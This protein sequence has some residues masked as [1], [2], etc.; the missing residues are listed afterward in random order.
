MS[1]EKWVISGFTGEHDEA[2][3]CIRDEQGKILATTS[4]VEKYSDPV[5]WIKYHYRAN[6]IAAA[7]ELLQALRAIKCAGCGK[8]PGEPRHPRGNLCDMCRPATVAIAKAEG[9]E[10][11][12]GRTNNNPTEPD[13]QLEAKTK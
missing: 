5:S 4:R 2:G 1:T 3:A 8:T 12:P 13:S 7:P 6:L 10:T 9:R 11:L